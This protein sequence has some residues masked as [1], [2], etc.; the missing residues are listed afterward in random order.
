VRLDPEHYNA[1]LPMI[2]FPTPDSILRNCAIGSDN[3]TG[4]YSTA[5]LEHVVEDDTPCLRFSGVLSLHVPSEARRRGMTHSGWA[6][7]RTRPMGA[8]LFNR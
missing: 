4:G 8:N 3:D 6:G 5:N 1:V 2:T 7:W